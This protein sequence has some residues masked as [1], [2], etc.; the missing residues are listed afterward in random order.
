MREIQSFN[1]SI[2]I[3][4]N[5]VANPKIWLFDTE[6]SRLSYQICSIRSHSSNGDEWIITFRSRRTKKHIATPQPIKDE[7]IVSVILLM[8]RKLLI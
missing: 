7:H 2:S 6:E 8:A 3:I 5:K 4:S 1:N